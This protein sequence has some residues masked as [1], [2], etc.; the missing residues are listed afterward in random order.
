M[1]LSTDRILLAAAKAVAASGTKSLQHLDIGSGHGD[2]ITLLRS[3]GLVAH[4]AA[5]DYTPTLMALPDVDVTV[6][7][8]NTEPLPFADASF[9]LVTCTEVVEHLEHYRETL[10]EMYRVL[11]PAGRLVLT[12]PNILNLKSRIRFLIF[13]FYNLFGPLHT[14]ESN[15]HDTGGHINPVSSFYLSHSLIDAGFTDLKLTIDKRQSSSTFWLVLLYVPIKL[16]SM[17][18]VRKE[19]RRYKTMDAHNEPYVAQMNSVD[20][21]LGRTIVIGCSKPL[22][23]P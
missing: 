4:S 15:L 20:V 9:D 11:K 13:G 7:N 22:Q 19:K 17:L 5:C 18:I 2:L 1:A 14:L 12:T 6:A 21:L 3:K 8:L 23:A 16:F 10:R